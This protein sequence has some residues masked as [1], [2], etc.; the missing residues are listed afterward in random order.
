MDPE[1]PVPAV[2]H[3]RVLRELPDEAID[4][5]VGAAGPE[6]GSPLTVAELRHL[7]GALGRAPDD[8]GALAKL[9]ADFVMVGVGVAM[10]PEMG[11]AA[12]RNL[13]ALDS[14]LLSWASEGGYLNFA[15]QAGDLDQIFAPET[16]DRLGEIKRRW[17]PDGLIRANHELSL[18]TA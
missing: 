16:C 17:D 4:A 7:G 11:E 2:G 12:R 15:D 6:A 8:A 9:D 5:F 13:D 10:T 3:H 18:A 1:N 14:A